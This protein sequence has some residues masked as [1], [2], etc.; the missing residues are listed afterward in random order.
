MPFRQRAQSAQQTI[1]VTVTDI[2]VNGGAPA[3]A[4]EKPGS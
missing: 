1:D 4:F 2:K 3:G